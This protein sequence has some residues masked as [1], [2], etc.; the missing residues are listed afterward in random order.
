M[1]TGRSLVAR[2][3]SVLLTFRLHFLFLGPALLAD[4]LPE[5]VVG[6]IRLQA[7]HCECSGQIKHPS[8]S[9]KK[10]NTGSLRQA[11]SGKQ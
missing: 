5:V 1:L 4:G 6:G 3:R 10:H 2:E 11:S 8:H 7:S 9:A